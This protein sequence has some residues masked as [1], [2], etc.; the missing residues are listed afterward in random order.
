MVSEE[1]QY[2]LKTNE[3]NDLKK[4]KKKKYKRSENLSE[5]LPK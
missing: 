1:F 5:V 3:P 2:E 4:K